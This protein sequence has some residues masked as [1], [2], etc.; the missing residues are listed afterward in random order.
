MERG[1]RK[2]EERATTVM[3]GGNVPQVEHTPGATVLYRR[4]S[5]CRNP[6]VYV[7]VDRYPTDDVVAV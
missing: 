1:L 2:M 3:T 6:G 7:P 4:G 5:V